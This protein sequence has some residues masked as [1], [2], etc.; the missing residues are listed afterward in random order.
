MSRAGHG[1]AWPRCNEQE[2]SITPTDIKTTSEPSL[3][4]ESKDLLTRDSAVC[5]LGTT[6]DAHSFISSRYISP[7][8]ASGG[9]RSSNTN[10]SCGVVSRPNG[11]KMSPSLTRSPSAPADLSVDHGSPLRSLNMARESSGEC[12]RYSP[13]PVP[14]PVVRRMTD[15]SSP[16]PLCCDDFDR[17]LADA[18]ASMM[19]PSSSN[20]S[21]LLSLH[22]L[23]RADAYM[24]G[25]CPGWRRPTLPTCVPRASV[26]Q[27][28]SL[29]KKAWDVSWDML[30]YYRTQLSSNSS[31]FLG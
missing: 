28:E 14:P 3:E 22:S 8:D 18:D 1:V 15:M 6:H 9:S 27:V 16:F 29:I 30:A 12:R 25:V 19:H 17:F 4:V 21:A 20:T 24:D 7:Y 13:S 23:P 10:P 31:H 2:Q 5:H 26:R 11:K